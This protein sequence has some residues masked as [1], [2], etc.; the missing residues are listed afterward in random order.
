MWV[1]KFVFR[2]LGWKDEVNLGDIFIGKLFL[3]K[4]NI[5]KS[6]NK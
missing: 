4:G 1:K 3:E 2:V 5:G 6:I